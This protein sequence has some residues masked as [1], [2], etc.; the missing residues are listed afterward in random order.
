MPAPPARR[1]GLSPTHGL[2]GYVLADDRRTRNALLLLRWALGCAVLAV[3][4]VVGAFV[5]L[6]VHDPGGGW[7]YGG[8]SAL[9][10]VVAARHTRRRSRSR[11]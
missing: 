7:T 8:V 6:A 2:L 5:V 11:R 4:V 3:G 10:G 1:T 9:A